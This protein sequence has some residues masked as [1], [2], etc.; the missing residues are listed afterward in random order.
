MKRKTDDEIKAELRAIYADKGGEMPD[1]TKLDRRGGSW[2]TRVLVRSI[3]VLFVLS[4]IAWAGFFLWSQ[5]GILPG[6]PLETAVEAPETVRSGEETFY[7]FRYENAGNAPIAALGMKLTVPPDFSVTSLN[8]PPS[9]PEANA[10]TIGSLSRDSDGAITVGGVFRS[11]VPSE[12]T[13]QALY[14]YK[15]AN[16]SSDFQDISTAKVSVTESVLLLT[17]SG[18]EKALPGD[19]ATYVI[20]LQNSGLRDQEN[21]LVEAV[22]P[23]GFTITGANP[24]TT[25]PGSHAWKVASLAPGELTAITVTGTYT[26]SVTGEQAFGAR[27]AFLNVDGVEYTQAKAQTT[28]DVLGGAVAFHLVV[29]GSSANQTVDPGKPLRVSVDYANNGNETV[30]GLTFSLALSGTGT[31]PVDWSQAALGGGTR[32]GNTVTWDS[33]AVAAFDQFTPSTS[34]TIDLTV[35]TLS[36]L[37]AS[38]SS[39]VVLTLTASL[40]QIGS[41]ASPR[42][43]SASPITVGV[44]S[45]F[46]SSAHAEYYSADGVP[47]G[48][49]PLPPAVGQT[50]TYRLVW[51]VTNSFHP[52]SNVRMTTNLPPKVTWTGN[53]RAGAGSITFDETTRIVT[54]TIDAIPTTLP[55]A[56]ATFDVAIAPESADVGSFYKLTNAIAVEATDTVTQDQVSNGIDILTTE[57]PE[58]PMA[59]GKG[60]VVK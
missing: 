7:T 48:T 42:S 59:E 6:R 13:L 27:A 58:D 36:A 52:L 53:A 55:G 47:V 14:T 46:R 17:V 57:L 38:H 15:P 24:T 37:N 41:V 12:Q 19:E 20:N 4:A 16:F 9:D 29:N 39:T 50:T 31:L 54:W 35:P 44:N 32:S 43:I 22:A 1:L 30:Q 21:V 45:D 49:G 28:T 25:E 8:P 33:A 34:G 60:I 2:V 40:S 5:G 51:R 23:E 26:S 11:E 10:W 56:E 3:V 18:P